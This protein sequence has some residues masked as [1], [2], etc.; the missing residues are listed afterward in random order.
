MPCHSYGYE[1]ALSILFHASSLLISD[2]LD[3]LREFLAN[4]LAGMALDDETLR[5]GLIGLYGPASPLGWKTE[6]GYCHITVDSL[7]LCVRGLQALIDEDIDSSRATLRAWLPLPAE[8]LRIAEYEMQWLAASGASHPALVCARLHG[9]RLGDWAVTVE[10]AEGVLRIEQF[11]PRLRT[12]ALR[13]LGRAKA[14]LGDRAAACEASELAASEASGAKYLW[15][16]M[17]S[18]RDLLKWSEAREVESMKVRL[19]AVAGKT[20]ASATQLAG[21]LGEGVLLESSRLVL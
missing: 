4:S 8:L 14:A 15:L 19:R 2:D 10:V 13:L 12:E 11:N 1:I 5:S 18:L 17:L 6:E 16:E 3:P 7:M 20:A 21:V 9:E